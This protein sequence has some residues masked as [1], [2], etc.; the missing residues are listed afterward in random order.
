MARNRPVAGQRARART[1]VIDRPPAGVAAADDRAPRRPGPPLRVWRLTGGGWG[2][3]ARV[4]V[5][6]LLVVVLVALA[7]LAT[8]AARVRGDARVEAARDEA[9]AAAQEHAV[10]IL[11]YDYR[12]L[13]ADF[14]TARK[15]LTGSF[16]RDYRATTTKVVRP[17]AVQYQAVVKAEVAAS[18][19]VSASRDR[20]VVLLFVN[21]TT[22][23]TRLSGP[24][25]DLNRVRFTLDRVSGTWLVS[26]VEAL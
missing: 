14:A 7:A 16:A 26:N 3:R 1:A 8:V 4:A 19:V 6:A 23:S 15:A 12:H 11:S 18:S 17:G 21:Q 2:T 24:K 9:V 13:D 5:A 20:V 10:D 22:T 25:V